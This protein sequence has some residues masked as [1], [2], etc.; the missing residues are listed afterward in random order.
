MK[1][2]FA[3]PSPTPIDDRLTEFDRRLKELS[4]FTPVTFALIAINALV[5]VVM[6]ARGVSWLEPSGDALRAWGA[7]Y[8][9]QTTHGDGWRLFTC[10]F[11]HAGV[12]PLLVNQWTLYQFGNWLERFFGHVGLLLVYLVSGFVGSTLAV[13][14]QYEAV[15]AGS[16]P[17]IAGLIGALAAFLWRAPGMVPPR[18]LGRLR[19]STFVFL[20]YNVGVE[21]YRQRLD[22]AGFLGGLAIGF[23]AGLILSQ[24]L[25]ETPP[26]GRWYRNLVLAAAGLL[27]MAFAA[28]IARPVDDP[29]NELKHMLDVESKVVATYQSAQDDFAHDR[30]DAEKFVEVMNNQVLAPWKE[31]QARFREVE[32]QKLA[33]K[34]GQRVKKL[35][36]SM[37][38]REQAWGLVIDSLSQGSEEGMAKAA[39]KAAEADRIEA[40]LVAEIK[41]ES[42]VE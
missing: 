3:E 42:H 33:G 34:A 25:A 18:A 31:A 21:L 40:E 14:W 9:P 35:L 15:L 24:P 27:L 6:V 19:A 17:A 39:E 10:F 2:S 12:V 36:K 16:A 26:R 1:R 5:W 37:K 8:G 23:F 13:R 41:E 4:R 28:A 32:K 11:L 29:V 38:L 7:N 20:G 30:I 22:S